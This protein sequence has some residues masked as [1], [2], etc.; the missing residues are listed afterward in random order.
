MR[1]KI[2]FY[3]LKRVG[4][5]KLWCAQ[6]NKSCRNIFETRLLRRSRAFSAQEHSFNDSSE[7]HVPIFLT[8]ISLMHSAHRTPT[9]ADPGGQGTIW[10]KPLGLIASSW[11]E[12]T[13]ASS[14][15]TVLDH[16]NTRVM[17][18]RG[19]EWKLAKWAA[20]SPTDQAWL[21][22][23]CGRSLKTPHPKRCFH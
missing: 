20:I 12:S 16:A 21:W 19:R 15:V 18:A 22:C 5:W 11:T 7:A 14:I 10:V 23:C 2:K 1:K 8:Y 6:V 9:S 3:F 13:N 4:V 17:T